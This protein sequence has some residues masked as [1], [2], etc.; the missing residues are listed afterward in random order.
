[1]PDEAI[2]RRDWGPGLP[3]SASVAGRDDA[4]RRLADDDR[5]VLCRC[6]PRLEG[7][8]R[9]DAPPCRT[10]VGALPELDCVRRGI[11]GRRDAVSGGR[12]QTEQPG[13]RGRQLAY[14][15]PRPPPILRH[16]DGP[17]GVEEEG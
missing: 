6:E 12:T 9:G 17:A 11:R 8:R 14:A 10:A 4:A 1:P 7:L 5:R 13:V 2:R 16:E 3:A 15:L